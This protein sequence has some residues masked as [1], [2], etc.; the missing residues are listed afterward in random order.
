MMKIYE[1]TS[2]RLCSMT[3]VNMGTGKNLA[4]KQVEVVA[5]SEKHGSWK[6][7]GIYIYTHNLVGEFLV[8][9]F[10]SIF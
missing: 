8:F 5:Y 9:Q 2:F 6:G 4:N 1:S 10:Y 3:E 7:I